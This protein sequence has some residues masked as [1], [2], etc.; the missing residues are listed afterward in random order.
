MKVKEIIVAAAYAAGRADVAEYLERGVGEDAGALERECETLLRCFS[1]AESETA[2]E[3]KPL[4]A[5]ERVTSENGTVPYSALARRVLDVKKVTFQGEPAPFTL[6][7]ES[8]KTRA[9]EVEIT[10]RYA[11]SAKQT[12]GDSDFGEG[13]RR[14]L[15]LGTACEYMLASG[16]YDEAA[17]W[18]KR[19]RA[20]LAAVCRGKGFRMKMRRWV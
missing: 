1:A 3:Y 13:E 14:A 18:N 8:L 9:G 17:I 7:A 16:L 4:Y 5:C 19:Y 11:P 12:E 15:V 2:L 20:S 10:Y 6:A